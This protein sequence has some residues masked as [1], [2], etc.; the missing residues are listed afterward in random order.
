VGQRDIGAR[1]M[2]ASSCGL[3]ALILSYRGHALPCPGLVSAAVFGARQPPNPFIGPNAPKQVTGI[4]A[5]I[6]CGTLGT[7]AIHLSAPR[8]L[9]PAEGSLS[10]D[11]SSEVDELEPGD[12]L[13][14]RPC[15]LDLLEPGLEGRE[16]TQWLRFTPERPAQCQAPSTRNCCPDLQAGGVEA[17]AQPR[18]PASPKLDSGA[19]LP[20]AVFG[21]AE[22][23]PGRPH[24]GMHHRRSASA[25]ALA[26]QVPPSSPVSTAH[27]TVSFLVQ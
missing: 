6:V 25:A 14:V 2:R 20:G 9:S 17:A 24:Q 11:D 23:E 27:A 5:I 26:E 3:S 13:H 8:L 21:E 1:G 4:F 15:P 19:R 22:S 18:R 12:R 7:L 16:H 10:G